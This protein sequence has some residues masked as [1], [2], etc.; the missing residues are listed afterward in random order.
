M[1]YNRK[2]QI[3]LFLHVSPLNP[4][5]SRKSHNFTNMQKCAMNK[6][7]LWIVFSCIVLSHRL[8]VMFI[9]AFQYYSQQKFQKVR[10]SEWKLRKTARNS[11]SMSVFDIPW[12]LIAYWHICVQW[13]IQ[14]LY[15]R[16]S[17]AFVPIFNY[18]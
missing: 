8:I 6:E 11:I 5:F 13:R 15:E 12:K 7:C 4:L 14:K 16:R 10:L 1:G 2:M 17:W 3:D 18:F 9:V